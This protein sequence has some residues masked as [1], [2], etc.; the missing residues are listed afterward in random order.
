MTPAQSRTP[1]GRSR[2]PQANTQGKRSGTTN[3]T[4]PGA[5]LLISRLE[6]VTGKPCHWVA[7]CP[8]PNHADRTPSLRI[9]YGPSKY[10]G[11]D[12]KLL[13]TCT[14]TARP[15][16]AV[17]EVL[18]LRIGDVLRG[19]DVYKVAKPKFVEPIS[20]EKVRRY[21]AALAQRP[22]LAKYLTEDRGLDDHTIRTYELGWDE[23]RDRYTLPVRAG[24]QL[25]NIRRYQRDASPGW[26]IINASGHGSPARLYPT[27]P[28]LGNCGV[29]VCEGEW[30]A[31]V[32]RRHGFGAC[33]STHGKGVWL[34]EW[35]PHF[36]GRTVAFIY[37]V[38]A[39]EDAAAHARTL[40]GIAKS[41]RT[42]VLPLPFKGDDVSDWFGA[43]GHDADDL[44]ALIASTERLR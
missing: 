38:G 18:G 8:L 40:V 15:L 34:K 24:T 27:P 21:A 17:C 11:E 32:L 2:G 37:D 28:P 30:D 42:V 6:D 14:C 25:V 16:P 33:T 31:L 36:K 7:R 41:V 12:W 35:A 4:E 20:D 5:A 3:G 13:V 22:N 1:A 9:D 43:Y 39:E 26:K 29:V 23:V 44:R 10:P 19:N